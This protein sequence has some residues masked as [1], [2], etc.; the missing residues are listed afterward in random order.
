M[1]KAGSLRL[2]VGGRHRTVE[3]LGESFHEG[4]THA[5]AVG[6]GCLDLEET[7]EDAL[8]LILR[9]SDTRILDDDGESWSPLCV[10]RI[11]ISPP[12]G[13]YFTEL[14]RRL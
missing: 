3:H 12:S 10:A 4:Q 13:V 8:Q 6:V 9:N 14:L 5:G 1:V 7:L 2:S 11:H